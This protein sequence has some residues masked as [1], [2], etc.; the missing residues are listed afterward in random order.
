[1]SFHMR[2]F[3]LKFHCS[4]NEVYHLKSKG[5]FATDMGLVICLCLICVDIFPIILFH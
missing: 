3:A 4:Y 2:Q 5:E 1:M